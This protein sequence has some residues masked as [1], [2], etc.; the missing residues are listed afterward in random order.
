[1]VSVSANAFAIAVADSVSRAYGRDV[2]ADNVE[3]LVHA[4][5]GGAPSPATADRLLD[6]AVEGALPDGARRDSSGP[7]G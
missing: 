6:A 5:P 2:S 4:R 1:M 7:P 3:F